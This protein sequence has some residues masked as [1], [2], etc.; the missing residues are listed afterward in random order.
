MGIGLRVAETDFRAIFD[1]NQQRVRALLTRMVGR[2]EAEDL[3]QITF[4][5]AAHALPTFHG[6]ADVST[7]LHRIAVNVA[8]DWL[9]SRT[10]Q[11][12]KLTIPLPGPSAEEMGALASAAVID[13]PRTPDQE[14]AQKDVHDCI[15]AEIAKLPPQYK[16]VL[17]LSFLGQLNDTEIA[18]TL[19]ITP[20][21]AKVRL[22]RARQEFKKI[23]EP[24]CNFYQ[25]EFSCKPTSP[26]CCDSAQ[27]P[28]S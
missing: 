25:S 16:E 19:G 10:A 23:I 7:W 28:D 13:R 3:A 4:A 20:G 17:T 11:E 9:R 15:R 8:L 27:A 18:E 22:H 1:A 24:R 26:D 5:K 14:V 12:A 2:Q 21:S 6:D